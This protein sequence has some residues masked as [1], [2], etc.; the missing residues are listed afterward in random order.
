MGRL[1]RAVNANRDIAF[2][3]VGLGRIVKETQN[4][5]SISSAY[6]LMGRRCQ[7]TG[8]DGHSSVWEFD[9]NSLPIE[10][11]LPDAQTFSFLHDSRGRETGRRLPGGVRVD[12]DYDQLDRLTRQWTGFASDQEKP[13]RTLQERALKYDGNGNPSKIG[14]RS[15]GAIDISYDSV[16][17]VTQTRRSGDEEQYA[18]DLAGNLINAIKQKSL[19]TMDDS[20]AD[21]RGQRIHERGKLM[22]AGKVKYEYDLEGRVI[23]R[24]DGPESGRSVNKP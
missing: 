5:R 7:R 1:E 20:N 9:A 14:E 23:T 19:L 13:V 12:Q 10:L 3:R 6:D 21:A 4:G 11:A 24:T 17:R 18:Y 2:E 16:G 8:S 15:T 22:Q